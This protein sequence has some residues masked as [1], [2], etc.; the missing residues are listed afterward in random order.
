MVA[1]R[2]IVAELDMR[3]VPVLIMTG[4]DELGTPEEL[5]FA[6]VNQSPSDTFHDLVCDSAE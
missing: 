2:A 3:A 4:F 1:P 6:E 5:Q